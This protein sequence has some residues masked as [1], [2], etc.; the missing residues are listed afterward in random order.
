MIVRRT[1]YPGVLKVID[2][3]NPSLGIGQRLIIR[4]GCRPI[5]FRGVT[6]ECLCAPS[7]PWNP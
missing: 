6:D 7:A 1:G 3:P 4:D 5:T 2:V